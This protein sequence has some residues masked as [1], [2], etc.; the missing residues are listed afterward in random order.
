MLPCHC[1]VALREHAANPD[2][3]VMQACCLHI[4]GGSISAQEGIAGNESEQA[5]MQHTS[6]AA[7]LALSY[8]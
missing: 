6:T 2:Q 3:C 8:Q 5:D 7:C 1:N 4:Q